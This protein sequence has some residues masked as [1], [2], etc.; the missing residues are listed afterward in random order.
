MLIKARVHPM[1]YK[2]SQFP[3]KNGRGAVLNQKMRL[4][5]GEEIEVIKLEK[6]VV[7]DYKCDTWFWTKDWLVFENDLMEAKEL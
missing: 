1:L 4:L 2:H 6:H 3:N 5:A 7:F